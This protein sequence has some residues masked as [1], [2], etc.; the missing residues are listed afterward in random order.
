M[1]KLVVKDI[2]KNFNYQVLA[3]ENSL[4]REIKVYG[5]NRA[6]LEL[7]GFDPE[8][9]NT[10]RRVI[11]LSHKEYLYISTLDQSTRTQRYEFILNEH[12][13][14]IILTDRFNDDLLIKIANEY[15]CPI[16]R[17]PNMPTS[18]IY[19]LL[20]EFF[21]EYFAPVIEEHASLVN[22]FGK[23]VLLKGKSGIGKSEM[24]LELVK[25]NHLF[26]GDDRILLMQKNNKIYGRSH[27]ILKNL[28]EVRGLGIIDLS[29]IYGLQVL[30]EETRIDLIVELIH[31]DDEEY[32]SIDR[33]GSEYQFVKIFDS[34]VPTITIPVT[35][36]RNV[37]ELVE[38]AV[39]KLKL[40]EA[41]ISS[42]KILQNRLHNNLTK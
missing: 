10:N 5:I 32:K 34:L 8:K 1:R 27:E 18:R 15:Q 24:T 17:A 20:L 6:G 39:A 9:D 28:I 31:L 16:V 35:Y 37:S 7:S 25:K 23:G 30:L 11:L 19:Q 29:K 14:M 38:T 41:G 33:L 21:D 42:T 3:G 26:V 22:V 13:P 2:I 12:I 40:E 4:E 36:G